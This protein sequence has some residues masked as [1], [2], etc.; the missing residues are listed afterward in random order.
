MKTL[1]ISCLLVLLPTLLFAEG[2]QIKTGLWD[3]TSTSQN[4][5]MGAATT[6]TFQKCITEPEFDPL[7]QMTDMDKEQCKTNSTVSG[8]QLN[9]TIECK[10]P[11]AG[12]FAGQGLFVSNRNTVTGNMEMQGTIDGQTIRMKVSS[13]G[14]YAGDC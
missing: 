7:S 6:R 3:I 8:N 9:F 13:E 5:M 2:L 14:T 4:S 11:Q 10:M 12:T 1:H